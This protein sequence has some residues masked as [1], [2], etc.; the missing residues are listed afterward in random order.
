MK[1]LQMIY[2]RFVFNG[3]HLCRVSLT[4][5]NELVTEDT[6]NIETFSENRF[7]EFESSVFFLDTLPYGKKV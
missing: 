5:L 2:T 3:K 1:A 4:F 6:C 7:L